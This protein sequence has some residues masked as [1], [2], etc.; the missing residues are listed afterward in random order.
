MV[1]AGAG[2]AVGALLIDAGRGGED[3]LRAWWLNSGNGEDARQLLSTLLTAVI[4]MASMVFS[5]TVVAL[6]LAANQY[7]SRLVRLFRADLRNQATLGVFAGTIVYCVIVLR[8]AHGE[9]PDPEVPHVAVTLGTAL[10]LICVLVLLVF[11]QGVA[12]SIVADEVIARV[13]DDLKR[14][15]A[16]LPRLDETRAPERVRGEPMACDGGAALLIAQQQEGYVETV[17]YSGLV[18]WAARHDAVVRLDLR[19]GDFIVAGDERI[20]VQAPGRQSADFGRELRSYI[21]LG[22]ERTPVQDIEFSVRHLVEIAVRAL[23]PGV[24][25]PFTATAVLNRLRAALSELMHRALPSEVLRDESGNVRVLATV[26]TYAGVIDAA[27]HQIRQA[28]SS[29]PA[30][31]IHMLEVI[32]RIAEHARLDEQVEALKRH[33]DMITSSALRETPE[34]GDRDD[35]EASRRTAEKALAAKRGF[36][37]RLQEQRGP[38]KRPA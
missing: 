36:R 18:E 33:V 2:L 35:I 24:N 29:K 28:G 23:S 3:V 22:R 5:I 11:I 14:G 31:T 6:T 9:A 38:T 15:V 1:I 17:D 13:G 37:L 32:A 26:T 30:I 4:A 7:G 27:F 12:R 20:A 21:V 25:D 10:S 19:P 16:L 8:A 34:Q